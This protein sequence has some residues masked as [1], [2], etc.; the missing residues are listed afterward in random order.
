M[1]DKIKNIPE[2]KL[3]AFSIGTMG[4][5]TLSK[6]E[7]EEQRKKEEER[8]AAHVF[9]E[10]VATF[11]ESPISSSSKV[12]VKAGTYD[13]GARK[14]DTKD[15][16]KLY[17]PQSR[18]AP[19]ELMASTEKAQF[20][21]KLIS[22]KKPER[23]GK[24]KQHTKSN[25]EAF[26]EELRQIQEEREERHKY[27]GVLRTPMESELD[28][29]L[30]SGDLGSFD[31]GDPT[32]TN[33]YLGNL[34][35][36]ITEQQ[37]MEI[38]G[39][40]GPLA[41]IKIMWPRSDEEKARGRNCGF[42]AYMSRKDGERALR[43]LN[44]KEILGYEMKLGWGKSVIIPPHPI[45][46][47]PALL[48]LSF[49]P[50]PS[51]LPFNAQPCARDKDV[52]PKS[53]EELNEILTRSVV[54][55]VIP[56]DRNLL[57]LIHRMVE[58]VVREGPMLEA[59][60][61]NREIHNPNYRFLFENQSPAHIYYRW[62]LYSIMHGDSQKEWS[63]KEFRLFKSGS[64]WKPPLM[65]SYTAGMPDELV[66]DDEGKE[67]TKGSLSNTQRDR[68]EDLIR[69]LTPERSKI[70]EAMVFCIEHSD[71][72]EE[73]VECI[74]ESLS[75]A[76]T[77][78]TKKIARLYLVSDI[79]HNCGVKVNNASYY[80]KAFE[81]KLV[82]IM[83]EVKKSY[84]KLEGRLQA[85]GCK[86]RVLR[87]LQALDDSIY[88]KDYVNKLRTIFLGIKEPEP[89]EDPVVESNI[90]IDGDPLQDQPETDDD[91]P[92]DGATLLKSAMKRYK[93]TTISNDDID[94]KEIVDDPN[95]VV[96]PQKKPAVAPLSG[97]IMSKWE[98]IDPEQV[99][100]QAMTTSKWDLLG[101][102]ADPSQDGS[103]N[104]KE[105]SIDYTDTRN[106][107]EERR[108]KL[109]EIE[110][111]AVQYQDELESGQRALKTGWT[112]PQQ[113]E[114]Y[115][116]KLLKKSE[117][118]RKDKDPKSDKH[119]KDDRKEDSSE[120][121]LYYKELKSRKSK[122][123]SRSSSSGS[124]S[125]HR[126]KS[127]SPP[128][129]KSYRG[130]SPPSP[131][132]IRRQ[133]PSSSSRSRKSKDSLSPIGSSN[134]KYGSPARVAKSRRSP[135]PSR[136]KSSRRSSSPR[137]RRSPS[138]RSRRGSTSPYRSRYHSPESSRKHRHK[139][140]Y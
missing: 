112:L 85:E 50:P 29:F 106:M 66:N 138:P 23:L 1:G 60:I 14:E 9:E 57:M 126:S 76:S 132:H 59:M 61:M 107:T 94:G 117:K 74:T 4:K 82:D 116:R 24:K 46:I 99:E 32:T 27:K 105:D 110:V 6:K 130:P 22:D 15:K 62:K 3:K 16:G 114:H 118:E 73:V 35:P 43:N 18:L 97:F 135:S 51:G 127:R 98:T 42:V 102:S 119:K 21:A 80:R 64:I 48:E 34:N 136:T 133:S 134:G 49:P 128:R 87:I 140:K 96:L 108:N 129:K 58:F 67:N 10:F 124:T 5:R 104:D 68:L 55:V 77:L 93:N 91:V 89:K 36:K 56:T 125:K 44:G 28:M 7:L 33:L 113:V 101:S 25:L 40:Y 63:V 78:I 139:H 71:A 52:L 53:A 115:R 81:S 92:M 13:A 65:N 26:K 39:R 45:Y 12:W 109:R 95:D 79:L 31:N 83:T 2:Q 111:K 131:P 11:Q 121:E 90:D 72:A 47:P 88:H 8:A 122:K 19:T 123:L 38:F 120:D 69:S 86:L 54:K 100:A 137:N 84:D 70:G 75:N 30:R 37:L 103:S 17:K 41:S 20:Y